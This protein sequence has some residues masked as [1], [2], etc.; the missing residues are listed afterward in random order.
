MRNR[1]M[2]TI[3]ISCLLLLLAF[4]L[5]A[6]SESAL[7]DTAEPEEE[8]ATRITLKDEDSQVEGSG[9]EMRGKTLRIL[10][11]GTY[12]ISGSLEDG[13]I[14][15]E[16]EDDT[17]VT[18][19]FDGVTVQNSTEDALHIEQ[20]ETVILYLVPGSENQLQSGDALPQKEEE[21]AKGG[22]LYSR[23]DLVIR[24]EGALCVN[25][26]VHDAIHANDTLVIED[27]SLT[28]E[29]IHHAVKANDALDIEGGSLSLTSGQDG[30]QS[31]GDLM[32]RGGKITISSGDDAVH[33]DHALTVSGGEITITAS[34]EGL[35]ANQVLLSGGDLTIASSD[36]GINAYGGAQNL[37]KGASAKT[38]QEEPSLTIEG[39]TI[40]VNAEGDGLD[41]NGD[42]IINGGS[43]LVDGPDMSMNGALDSGT[44][45]GGNC[46]VNG[47]TVLAIGASGMAEGF[48]PE[49]AQ[50]SFRMFLDTAPSG[51][52]IVI[53]DEDGEEL[54][55]H[56]AA[57]TFSSLVFSSPE[58]TLG[59][60]YTVRVAD[61]EKTISLSSV[62]ETFSLQEDVKGGG[63]RGRMFQ[64]N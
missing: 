2:H 54:I 8:G 27:G 51:S 24:G 22:A 55:R 58:L 15:V 13:Q 33:A 32:I 44:E 60:K 49:S 57:K 39:G 9:A 30:L 23:D 38:T 6:C 3:F 28:V 21:D 7:S 16:A 43:V 42:L 40:Y 62:A 25:G 46:A 48:G 14:Y 45:N 37:G 12:E 61:E 1:R 64:R 34:V 29:A 17:D 53:E 5:S 47:G 26:Y 36:D 4:S 59:K 31:E 56:T 11:G 50:N 35:E 19:Y 52:E 18:L 63:F 10:K 20:A 41:S